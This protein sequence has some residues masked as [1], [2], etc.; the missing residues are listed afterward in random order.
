MLR[1][2][3][4]RSLRILPTAAS[5]NS[6]YILASSVSHHDIRI[7]ADF[8]AVQ[9]SECE[10]MVYRGRATF[11]GSTGAT[12]GFSTPSVCLGCMKGSHCDYH[13]RTVGKDE[14]EKIVPRSSAP[15]AKNIWQAYDKCRAP[16]C[17]CQEKNRTYARDIKKRDEESRLKALPSIL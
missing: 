17:P 15:I 9:S 1:S 3:R 2:N 8:L 14:I 11:L 5:S 7:D 12:W 10:R 13:Q 6:D 4:T 16:R